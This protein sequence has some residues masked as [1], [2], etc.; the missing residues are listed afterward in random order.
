MTRWT[1]WAI[2][3][4][5][6]CN[7]AAAGCS[8]DDSTDAA[9]D[10]GRTDDADVRDDAP[11]DVEPDGEDDA[12]V[13]ADIGDDDAA[14][15]DAEP[16]ADVPEDADAADDAEV[17]GGTCLA[18][19]PL[20]CGDRLAG[21]NTA[22][23]AALLD[24]YPA[25]ESY[26]ETGPE[27]VYAFTGTA[28]NRV[29]IE[30]SPAGGE[31]LDLFL[32]GAACDPAACLASSAST[33]DETLTFTAEVG[34][35]YRVVVDGFD[36]VSGVYELAVSCEVGEQC[37]ND[38]DDNGNGLVDCVDSECWSS[39]SC[40]ESCTGG[41]DEDR[42]GLVDCADAACAADPACVERSCADAAD[43]DADGATDCADWDCV[44]SADCGG[45]TEAVGGPCEAH[46]ACAGRACLLETVWGWAGGYCTQWSLDDDTCGGCPA[47]STC[48]DYS[49][50]GYGPYFCLSECPGGTGCRA[51]SQTCHTA[52]VCVGGCTADVQCTA[53]GYCAPADGDG[54][55]LCVAPPELCVGG[56][57]EDGDTRS[58]CDDPDC[59]FGP[60][61]IAAATTREG[62]AACPGAVALALPTGERGATVVSGT[63]DA[64][65]GNDRLP[66]CG[67]RDSDDVFYR[68]ALTRPARVTVRLESL[69]PATLAGPMVALAY[70]CDEPDFQCAAEQGAALLD[71]TLGVG[72]YYLTV[73]AFDGGLGTYRLGLLLADP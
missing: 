68:F 33:A 21:E 8:D 71:L 22:D 31:D 44:G 63:L 39:A 29:T 28:A 27:S 14:E 69:E 41:L 51:E 24:R 56:A 62:S 35:S 64:G 32:L 6:C 3:A 61:C 12:A 36:G 20:A 67:Y 47:G 4:A 48:Y 34:T 7:V 66:G 15:V 42:D 52:G 26:P 2:L 9:P 72:T 23:G 46:D 58:D 18:P 59:A 10:D 13:E 65:D 37:G 53:T 38:A 49:G 16:E 60:P 40:A 19:R 30:L 11:P 5:A 25:C 54:S 70:A 57:D 55:R 45:G 50:W 43:D 73:D 1:I 17:T